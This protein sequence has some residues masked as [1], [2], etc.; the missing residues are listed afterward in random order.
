MKPDLS[1]AFKSELARN[2]RAQENLAKLLPHERLGVYARASHIG[3]WA[4]LRLLVESLD[5]TDRG[6]EKPSNEYF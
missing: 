2:R 6:V 5:D 3:E 4:N 1:T